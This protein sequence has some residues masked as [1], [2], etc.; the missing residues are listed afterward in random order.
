MKKLIMLLLV[1]FAFTFG[2]KYKVVGNGKVMWGNFTITKVNNNQFNINGRF[3]CDVA[4]GKVIMYGSINL[5]GENDDGACVM[6]GVLVGLEQ[7]D[8]FK[9][10]EGT[11]CSINDLGDDLKIGFEYKKKWYEAILVKRK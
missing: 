5:V 4:V 9:K 10:M 8:T 11:Y 7:N 3:T 6:G 2:E 1:T